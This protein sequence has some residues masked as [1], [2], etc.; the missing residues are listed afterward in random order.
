MKRRLYLSFRVGTAAK[1]AERRQ[2]GLGARSGRGPG[3]PRSP[4]AAGERARLFDALQVRGDQS[5][6]A[7]AAAPT[8]YKTHYPLRTQTNAVVCVPRHGLGRLLPRL[9][10]VLSAVQCSGLGATE[11]RFYRVA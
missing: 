2:I 9:I 4:A 6:R 7:A 3:P 5:A 10:T 1:A 11:M 8:P